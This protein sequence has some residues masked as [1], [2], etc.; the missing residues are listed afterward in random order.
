MT[1]EPEKFAKKYLNA[2]ARIYW[3]PL[4]L[5]EHKRAFNPCYSDQNM[6]F[7]DMMSEN[8]INDYLNKDS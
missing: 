8:E 1:F 6:K 5:V 7:M 3:R 2:K 4:D